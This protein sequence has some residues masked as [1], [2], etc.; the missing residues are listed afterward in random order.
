MRPTLCIAVH[1]VAPATWQQC[2]TLLDLLDELGAPPATLLVVPQ[3][4][5]LGSIAADGA[6]VRAIDQ[7]VARGDELALHGYY[8]LDDG[9]ASRTP[10]E[11]LQRRHLTASEGEFAALTQHEAAARIDA[12]LRLFDRFGWNVR[13]FVAPAWLLGAGARA[14]L[15]HTSLRY[16]S[17]H[18]HLEIT[19]DG[20]CVAAPVISASTRSAWRR[21]TSRRWLR[22][23]RHLTRKAP[24]LRVALHPADA[25]HAQMLATW[26]ALLRELLIDRMPLTK[27][28]ALGFA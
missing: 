10:L 11:W 17:T 18:T 28:A 14:A 21:W 20:R 9:P 8:H 1:D 15:K 16:T 19:A 6:F 3:Y 12:G 24:L 27:S 22:A 25:S 23:A 5:R 7:R 13:G 26:R 2:R 4:H